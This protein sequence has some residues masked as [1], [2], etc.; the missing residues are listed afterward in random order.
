M[1]SYGLDIS[2]TLMELKVLN[3]KFAEEVLSDLGN[4]GIDKQ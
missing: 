2:K 4:Y 1:E 3:G